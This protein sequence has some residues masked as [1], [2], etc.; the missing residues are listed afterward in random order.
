MPAMRSMLTRIRR[1]EAA[2]L[3]EERERAAVEAIRDTILARQR[4][5]RTRL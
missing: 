1:L 5:L 3:P 4:A 2:R